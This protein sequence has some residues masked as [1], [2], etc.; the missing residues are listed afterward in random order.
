MV[1]KKKKKNYRTLSIQNKKNRRLGHILFIEN[2]RLKQN[3]ESTKWKH[4]NLPKEG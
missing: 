1:E 4:K 3:Y 2:Q